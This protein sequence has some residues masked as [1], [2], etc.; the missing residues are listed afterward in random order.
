MEMIAGFF[1]L[2]ITLFVIGVVLGACF[3]V[4]RFAFEHAGG[5]LLFIGAVIVIVVISIIGFAVVN[6]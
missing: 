6:G 4:L 3:G 5:I 2:L 1:G